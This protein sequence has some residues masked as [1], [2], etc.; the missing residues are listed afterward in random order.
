[1]DVFEDH[2]GRHDLGEAL[3]EEAPG[4]KD[5]LPVAGGPG[6]QP[7]QAREP[8]LDPAAFLRIG[9]DDL[10]RFEELR[11]GRVGI[12]ALEDARVRANHLGE[13]PVGDALAVRKAAAAVPACVDREPV[14]VLEELP[15]ESRL[16]DARAAD[17]G[18]Q[19]RSVV[20]RGGVEELLDHPQLSVP[21]GERRLER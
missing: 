8:R 10:D 3:V 21:S 11:K 19:L 7:E 17:N 14:E 2:D 5:V 12:L 18:D 15:H 1:M 20:V 9:Q 16:A 4:C 6:L 13:G